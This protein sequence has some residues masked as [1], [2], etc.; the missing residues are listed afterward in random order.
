MRS[1]TRARSV[2][3]GER[4]HDALD[5]VE[6]S[7]CHCRQQATVR[8]PI[9]SRPPGWGARRRPGDAELLTPLTRR[10][11]A[12]HCL[13]PSSNRHDQGEESSNATDRERASV[14][15]LREFPATEATE[16]GGL[17]GL[18][19]GTA[20]RHARTSPATVRQVPHESLAEPPASISRVERLGASDHT[21]RRADGRRQPPQTGP[22]R[23]PDQTNEGMKP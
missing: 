9:T 4:T 21:C 18:R 1:H 11:A 17:R 6:A 10:C 16:R 7:S 19:P 13:T 5:A 20:S 15:R 8:H 22:S 2:R 3:T 14:H 23:C 12:A